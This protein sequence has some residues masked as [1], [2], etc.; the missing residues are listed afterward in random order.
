MGKNF[1]HKLWGIY[2]GKW[3]IKQIEHAQ[4]ART[5]WCKTISQYKDTTYLEDQYVDSYWGLVTRQK[6]LIY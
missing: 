1:A 2:P 6:F 5:F 4:Y 3:E